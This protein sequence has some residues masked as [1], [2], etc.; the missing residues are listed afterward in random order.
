M[1][2]EAVTAGIGQLLQTAGRG[3]G[4]FGVKG[5]PAGR[6]N[7]VFLV[8]TGA[9]R[10]V[11]KVYQ[12]S[13]ED[14]RDRLR[15][16]FD[17]LRHAWDLG[18]RCVPRP[19]ASEP[20][21]GLA[22][23]EYVA[24]RQL[25][26]DDVVAERVAEAGRF[27]A[28]LNTPASRTRATHLGTASD[29]CFSVAEHLGSVDRRV[30]RLALIPRTTPIDRGASTLG[31]DL[32]RAWA[33]LRA[34]L[35]AQISDAERPVPAALRCLSPS[36]FGFH[37][38]VLTPSGTLRFLDFEYAGWDDP[39]KM[40]GDFF[41]HPGVPVPLEHWDQF[42]AEALSPFEDGGSVIARARKLGPVFQMRWCCIMLNDF[43]PDA[44]RRRQFA[45]PEADIEA[46]QERQLSKAR[47]AL[48]TLL[49]A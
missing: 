48:E 28:A 32:S 20:E 5:L 35:V 44:A 31:H 27:F 4:R 8:E 30:E 12:R 38:A 7:R 24:G 13:L 18:L 29:A 3:D 2:Q 43:V 19:I 34:R 25:V 26:R 40:I 23:Y 21:L 41:A 17:F 42:V 33:R 45:N 16:E 15:S 1:L 47:L 14:P 49:R 36:D 37:N 22:L 46:S 9:E 11:V 6:N 10:F 39:A